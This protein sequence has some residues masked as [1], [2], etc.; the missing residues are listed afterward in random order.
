[1]CDL[2]FFQGARFLAIVRSVS[3][4]FSFAQLTDF[5]HRVHFQRGVRRYGGHYKVNQS[6]DASRSSAGSSSRR[7]IR[8]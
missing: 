6:K 2:S 7:P 5:I 3:E 1:M 4:N 8:F